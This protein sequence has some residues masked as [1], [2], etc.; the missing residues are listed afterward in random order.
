[1][2]EICFLKISPQTWWPMSDL[3]FSEN[4]TSNDL[5][6]TVDVIL[7]WTEF[8]VV[9]LSDFLDVVG[10]H[11]EFFGHI[12]SKTANSIFYVN[13]RRLRN[14]SGCWAR[15]LTCCGRLSKFVIQNMGFVFFLL[16]SEVPHRLSFVSFGSRL[17]LEG[18]RTG[19]HQ[20]PMLRTYRGF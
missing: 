18:G 16:K 13:S 17:S 14:R 10:R 12:Y 11:P 2:L 15:Q 20:M 9:V 3:I 8:K 4:Q 5:E 1:M 6:G 7:A 19:S